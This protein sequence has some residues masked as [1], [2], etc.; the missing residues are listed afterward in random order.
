MRFAADM[1]KSGNWREA[2]FRWQKVQTEDPDNARL[3]NNL[4]VAEEALGDRDAALDYYARAVHL[5]G[6]EPR[7]QEN[8]RRFVRF[9]QRIDPEFDPDRDGDADDALP[10][11]TGGKKSGKTSQ[12]TIWL[13]VPPRLDLT[14]RDSILVTSFL[15]DDSELLDVNR[16]LVRFLR[17]EFRKDT[18]LAVPDINPPPAIPEQTLED[19]LANAEFWKHLAR[20]YDVDLIVSGIVNYDR[21]DISGFEEVDVISARTG[22]TVRQTQFVEKEQFSYELDLFF[23]DGPTGRMLHRDRLQRALVF[24]GVQNDAI[25]A[26]HELSEAIAQDVLGVVTPRLRMDERVIFK[27]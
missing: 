21:A 25:T 9:W 1:A 19:L 23:I 16:E 22:Q 6:G 13:T 24:R 2:K 3:L 18:A 14:E 4:A 20:E 7:I 11:S 26:F 17:Q 10:A 15:T 8:Q 5:S 12:V 27:G